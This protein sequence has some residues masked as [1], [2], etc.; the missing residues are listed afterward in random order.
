MR[1]PTSFHPARLTPTTRAEAAEL[2]RQFGWL[3]LGLATGLTALPS[4]LPRLLGVDRRTAGRTSWLVGMVAGREAAVG[5][6][7]LAAVQTGRPDLGWPPQVFAD[8]GDAVAL[9]RA[10]RRGDVNR[11]V[12]VGLL[13]ATVGG[14]AAGAYGWAAATG[15]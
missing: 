14:V 6:A 1:L 13:L 4:L 10:L 12:G 3:R 7:T 15:E 2:A 8:A 5:V 11:L 9:L